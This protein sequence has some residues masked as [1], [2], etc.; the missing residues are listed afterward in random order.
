MY[1]KVCLTGLN[2]GFRLDRCDIYSLGC[3]LYEAMTRLVPFAQFSEKKLDFHHVSWHCE[4]HFTSILLFTSA[5]L[6]M[7]HGLQIVL[8][9]AN[10][11]RRPELPQ[12]FPNGL[13]DLI[14][15]CWA[16][17]P[18]SRPSATDVAE[19]L[20]KMIQD[21]KKESSTHL[22]KES[23]ASSSIPSRKRAVEESDLAKLSPGKE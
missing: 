21:E 18:I 2:S 11:K 23:H 7:F 8:A 4:A 10:D 3:I 17:D 13:R 14:E 1:F 15:S 16:D 20:E 22:M 12:S 9:V 5:L 19:R 6:L